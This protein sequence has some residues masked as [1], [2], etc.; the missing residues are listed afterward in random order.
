[1][2][3][4][5]KYSMCYEDYRSKL[6]RT[7]EQLEAATARIAQVMSFSKR[8]IESLDLQEKSLGEDWGQDYDALEDADAWKGLNRYVCV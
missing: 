4:L 7:T 5:E 3:K 1:M 8:N 6:I 2:T